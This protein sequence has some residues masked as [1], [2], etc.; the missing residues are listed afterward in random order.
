MTA[1][2]RL[3]AYDLPDAV[4]LRRKVAERLLARGRY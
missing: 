2:R 3:A 4:A 1:L